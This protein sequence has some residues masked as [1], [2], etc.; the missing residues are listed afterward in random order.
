MEGF[1][2]ASVLVPILR[3]PEG[4]SVLFTQRTDTVSRH[5]GQVS[6]PGG[7]VEPGED[8]TEAALRE[9]WEEVHLDPKLVEIAGALDDLPSVSSYMVTPWV[10]FIAE[11]PASFVRQESEVLEPFEVPLSVLLDPKSMRTEHW[12]ASMLPPDAPITAILKIRTDFEE[13]DPVTQKY[14]MY[15][16]DTPQN[17]VVWGL[18]GQVLKQL[19]DVAFGLATYGSAQR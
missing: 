1:A 12:D 18:T 4:P 17:R 3:R 10:G 13:L 16:F 11:P 14:R 7:R 8:H 15:F 5:K 9:A 6:F 2:H 19:L